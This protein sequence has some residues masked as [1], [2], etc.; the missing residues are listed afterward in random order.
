MGDGAARPEL[1][2]YAAHLTNV[3]FMDLQP[4]ERVPEMLNAADIHLV[5]QKQQAADLVMPSKLTNI[6]A[7]GGC[8][9]ATADAGTLHDVLQDVGWVV[10]PEDPDALA[11]GIDHLA[12]SPDRREKLASAARSYAEANLDKDA[13]LE[14]FEYDLA[15]L[16]EGDT[17]PRTGQRHFA[18]AK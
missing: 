4:W 5:V 2:A 17:R 7:V 11:N 9:L 13:I 18:P 12:G 16:C 6:L 15:S 3:R 8:V 1:E 10:V 14:R